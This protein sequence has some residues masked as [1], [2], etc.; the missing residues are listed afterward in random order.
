MDVLETGGDGCAGVSASV[1]DVL[2][3]VVIGV[4]EKSLDTGLN[5]APSTGVE[6]LLLTPDDSL[7]V[8]ILVKVLLELLPGEGVELLNTGQGNV[9]DVVIL[10]VLGEGSP[11][12]T[13]AEN[14]AVNLLRS[15]DGASLVL[16]VRDDPLE[17]SVLTGELLN[18]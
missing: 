15:L 12:L 16:R 14:H 17:A 8:G 9:V 5:E 10:T 3:V 2:A 7:G 13:T 11:D 18:V 6:G 4:V 1:H